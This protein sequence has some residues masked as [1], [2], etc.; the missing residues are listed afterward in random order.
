[1][2]PRV[3][4]NKVSTKKNPRGKKINLPLFLLI[5]RFSSDSDEE[6]KKSSFRGKWFRLTEINQIKHIALICSRSQRNEDQ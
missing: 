2:S 4:V 3:Y 5:L 1:M 6:G